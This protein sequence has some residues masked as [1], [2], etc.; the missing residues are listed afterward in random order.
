M[1]ELS[2]WVRGGWLGAWD[3]LVGPGATAGENVGTVGVGLLAA[4]LAGVEIWLRLDTTV[5]QVLLVATLAFDL[6]G[7]VWANATPAARR[8]Y[9]RPG[10]G[11][12]QLFGFNAIHLQ[13]FFVPWLFPKFVDGWGWAALLYLGVV[14]G[15]LVLYQ[16]PARLRTAG[17]LTYSTILLTAA[18]Q[19]WVAP[20]AWFA[21]AFILKLL[22]AHLL[23]EIPGQDPHPV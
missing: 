22:V 6:G 2:K 4:T 14:I 1:N 12:S 10:Q 15:T 17:A 23:P 9:H 13:P 11:F 8:W 16:L 21:P 7:G 3:R 20:V 5:L 18:T 19:F